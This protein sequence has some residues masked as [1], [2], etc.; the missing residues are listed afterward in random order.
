MESLKEF[1]FAHPV[2]LWANLLILLVGT[3]FFFFGKKSASH[4]SLEKW[5]DPHLLCHLKVDPSNRVHVWWKP[6]LLWSA[7]FACLTIALAGPRWSFREIE[8]FSKD[9]SVVLLLDLSES[10]NAPDVR[11]TRLVRAKQKIED[12]LN[13]SKGVKIGLVAFAADPH[14]I[15]PL[16]EDKETIRYL[17]PSLETDLVYVQG[18]RLST[19]FD[20][21]EGMLE[22]EPGRN[23]AILVLSDGGFEDPSAMASA[24][25]LGEKGV[26]VY[27]MG[28]GSKEGAPLKDREGNVVKK[29]GVPILSRL[30]KDKLQEISSLGKGRY[31]EIQGVDQEE[32][33]LLE[34]LKKRSESHLNWGK[35]NRIWDEY[36][37][38]FLLPAVPFFLWW[39]RKGCVLLALLGIFLPGIDLQA[40]SLQDLFKN[41]EELGK[42]AMESGEFEAAAAHFKD[43]YRAGVAYYKAG[44]FQEAEQ[45]FLSSSRPEVAAQ[46]L[47]NL[48]NT[49]VQQQKWNEAVKAYE[50]ALNKQPDY[51]EAHENLQLVKDLMKEQES[52]QEEGEGGEKKEG[53]KKQDS[54]GNVEEKEPEEGDQSDSQK[55]QEG[56]DSQTEKE[57]KEKDSEDLDTQGKEES[58]QE[59]GREEG[60]SEDEEVQPSK[61]DPSLE[62]EK[63][64]PTE[65]LSQED[66]DAD[67]WLNRLSNDPK[68]FLKSKF[69][70][71]SKRN[72]TTKGVD[73]W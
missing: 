1:H 61:E 7:V 11:P 14:M 42:K 66:L 55:P 30:E 16:T 60:G 20:M 38:L 32:S 9:Q 12:L 44:K 13:L 27:T 5:I 43:P 62:E 53:E 59:E 73:P 17:L 8:T 26:M 33:L 48:G 50:E 64:P 67:L 39:F 23:K 57:E 28:I 10:M 35:K 52:S 24:K 22:T 71:E 68:T 56:E 4:A 51:Q 3:L 54:E 65:P 6:L 31:L 29:N 25:K 49:Y 58:N 19:A 34:E 36:F 70:I 2:W 41:S 46:A 72:G 15:A 45:M 47:Y 37:Y 40:S 21:A 18:S 63:E 69:Y